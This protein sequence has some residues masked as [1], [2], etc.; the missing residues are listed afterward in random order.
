MKDNANSEVDV[1]LFCNDNYGYQYLKVCTRLCRDKDKNSCNLTV[2]WS[3]RGHRNKLVNLN[4]IRPTLV[5]IAARKYIIRFWSIMLLRYA[6]VK[7]VKIGDVNSAQFISSIRRNSVGIIAGFNQIF[8][9]RLINSFKVLVNFHPSLLP[10][11]RG[12]TPSYWVLKYGEAITGVTMHFVTTKIDEG[13][14]IY[15]DFLPVERRE[16]AEALDRKVSALGAKILAKYFRNIISGEMEK[17]LK[18]DINE[19]ESSYFSFGG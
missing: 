10:S 13:E 4:T 18:F 8:G 19:L 3:K 1:Y 14:L 9:S 5:F 11:Y 16:T 2:V 15:N 12:P 7:Y 6:R 17:D